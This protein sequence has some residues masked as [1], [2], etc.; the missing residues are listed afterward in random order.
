MKRKTNI[1]IIFLL[2]ASLLASVTLGLL[3]INQG[4][5]VFADI[6]FYV[7]CGALFSLIGLIPT[8]L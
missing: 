6:S 5:K 3:I 2:I 4:M 8:A 7:I 1:S